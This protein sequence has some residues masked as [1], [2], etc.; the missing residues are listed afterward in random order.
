MY[1]VGLSIDRQFTMPALT[2]LVSLAAATDPRL[3]RDISV[4]VISPDMAASTGSAMAAV[5]RRLGFASFDVHRRSEPDLP[6]VHGSY[7]TRTTYLRFAFRAPFVDRPSFLYLDADVLVVDDPVR[8]F[9]HLSQH[10]PVGLVR[11]EINHTVGAGPALPGLVEAVPEHA[12]KPYFN[13]GSVLDHLCGDSVVVVR[14]TRRR[15]VGFI[16]P[17]KPWQASCPTVEPV[18]MYRTFR[19]EAERL[20][21]RVG[22]RTPE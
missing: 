1:T 13:A 11:D 14:S 7:I 19:R 5:V 12:G 6:V 10:R 20:A 17:V 3:R 15:R 2:T 8:G 9:E 21:Q 22:N 4:R 16:G 18:R